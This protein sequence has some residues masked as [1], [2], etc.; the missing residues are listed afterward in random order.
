MIRLLWQ[1]ISSTSLISAT[2]IR[3][4]LSH[5]LIYV[6]RIFQ[7]SI[8]QIRSLAKPFGFLL[9]SFLQ[10]YT[11]YLPTND[12][13]LLLQA[14]GT[15]TGA[16]RPGGVVDEEFAARTFIRAFR[17]GKL[18]LW[19]LDDMGLLFRSPDELPDPQLAS[20]P[21]LVETLTPR[22]QLQVHED[23]QL[24][25]A[26][27]EVEDS[28]ALL[29]SSSG[30]PSL[31]STHSTTSLQISKYMAAYFAQ[32]RTSLAELSTSKHQIKKR[33]KEEATEK[34]KA[35]WKAKHPNLSAAAGGGKV[36]GVKKG[37]RAFFVGGKVHRRRLEKK[38]NIARKVTR[39][40][41]KK[42]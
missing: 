41:L 21:L 17:K 31:I 19:A 2:S 38:R 8:L 22:S 40:R 37:Q 11:S 15:R 24:V 29:R 34:R 1:T 7:H 16:L 20:K 35:K 27:P 33:A 14:I 28:L 3:H 32:Q 4:T 13:P 9:A 30:L 18:G 39:N 6:S 25:L 42:R 26:E 10:P 12:L 36:G 5:Y 23:H